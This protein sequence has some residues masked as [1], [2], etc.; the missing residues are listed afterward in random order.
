MAFKF[1]LSRWR[2]RERQDTLKRSERR[3][4]TIV[5]MMMALVFVPIIVIYVAFTI[6]NWAV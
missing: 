5:L 6:M 2:A 1:R 3:T 4:R